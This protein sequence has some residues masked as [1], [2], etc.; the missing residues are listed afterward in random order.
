MQLTDSLKSFYK[1]TAAALKGTDRRK[2]LAGLVLELGHGGQSTVMATVGCCNKT[3]DK[4]MQE[5]KSGIECVS[6]FNLRGRKPVEA[7]LP[8][9]RDDIKA[10][11]D[12]QSQTDP[13]FRNNR[14]YTRM[15]V[16]E[17]TRQLIAKDEYTA[18][19]LPGHETMRR[20][21]NE[22]G[23]HPQTVAKSQPKKRFRKPMQ[24]STN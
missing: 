20:I 19:E 15:S 21:V 11:V 24:F 13:Q 3:I 4:G 2:F 16:A 1:T 10:L 7:R 9:I 23:Y 5:L 18:E 8:R 12:G 6:A 17:I 14:L 22:L